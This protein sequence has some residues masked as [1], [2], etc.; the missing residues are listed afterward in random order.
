MEDKGYYDTYLVDEEYAEWT[1]YH[2]SDDNDED[3]LRVR[4]TDKD[5]Y[6]AEDFKERSDKC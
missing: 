2:S 1:D 4:R 3:N 6:F 5:E